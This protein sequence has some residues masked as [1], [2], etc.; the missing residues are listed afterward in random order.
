MKGHY[1]RNLPVQY[2]SV[3]NNPVVWLIETNVT[4]AL[5][6]S[7]CK[8]VWCSYPEDLYAATDSI[9]IVLKKHR[10]NKKNCPTVIMMIMMFLTTFNFCLIFESYFREKKTYIFLYGE[11][12]FL[13]FISNQNVGKC[14]YCM[15]LIYSKVPIIPYQENNPSPGTC[16]FTSKGATQFGFYLCIFIIIISLKLAR[17]YTIIKVVRNK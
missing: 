10:H 5:L 8:T 16:S 3:L 9:N 12:Y 6:H 1:I 13:F 2:G 15:W 14:M 7:P 4:A 17:N 11:I